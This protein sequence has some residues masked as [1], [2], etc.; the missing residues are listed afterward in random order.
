MENVMGTLYDWFCG[1]GMG[2]ILLHEYIT[3]AEK[4]RDTTYVAIIEM[5]LSTFYEVAR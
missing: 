5:A 1:E 4:K 3:I 2:V